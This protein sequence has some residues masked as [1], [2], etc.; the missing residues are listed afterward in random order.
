MK[1]ERQDASLITRIVDNLLYGRQKCCELSTDAFQPP[2]Y[3]LRPPKVVFVAAH[4]CIDG[5][6][7]YQGYLILVCERLAY[8]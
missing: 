8:P 3:E 6:T 7:F 5:K 2:C 1:G 4:E